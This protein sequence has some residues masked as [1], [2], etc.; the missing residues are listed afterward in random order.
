M[1]RVTCP[2]FIVHGQQDVMI[3]V[4]HANELRER[5]F[6]PCTF[7]SPETMTHNRFDVYEDVI[8]P[9]TNFLV[10]DVYSHSDDEDSEDEDVDNYGTANSLNNQFLASVKKVSIPKSARHAQQ[11]KGLTFRE[12]FFIPP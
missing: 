6:G 7:L 1:H 5:C 3:P 8:K 4:E 12:Q 10:D 11:S 2:T 9:L